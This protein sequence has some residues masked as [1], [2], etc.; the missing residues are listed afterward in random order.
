VSIVPDTGTELVVVPAPEVFFGKIFKKISL[1]LLIGSVRAD[2][3]NYRYS[4]VPESNLIFARL[5][6]RVKSFENLIIPE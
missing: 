2:A 5:K 1:L 4:M 6:R 3:H